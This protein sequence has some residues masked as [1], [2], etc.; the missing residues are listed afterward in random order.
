MSHSLL[1]LLFVFYM[2]IVSLELK[3]IFMTF[4][5]VDPN[6]ISFISKNIAEEFSRVSVKRF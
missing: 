2:P 4:H 6:I 3:K 1:L 5:V